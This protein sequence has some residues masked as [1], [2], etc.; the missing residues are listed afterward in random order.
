[1]AASGNRELTGD[2]REDILYFV[3][4][5]DQHRDRDDGDKSQDQGVLDEGLA[6]LTPFLARYFSMVHPIILSFFKLKSAGRWMK[7]VWG[8]ALRVLSDS[9]D[10]LRA[11]NR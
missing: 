8:D 1:M 9:G 7:M 3:T 5:P 4:Q 10:D 2:R 6:F 11:V